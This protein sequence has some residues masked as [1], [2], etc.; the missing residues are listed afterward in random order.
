MQNLVLLTH[1]FQKLSKKN[2]RG[3]ARPPP[4]VQ[5]GLTSVMKKKITQMGWNLSKIPQGYIYVVLH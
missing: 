5:E 4:L 3:S 2:L 1:V